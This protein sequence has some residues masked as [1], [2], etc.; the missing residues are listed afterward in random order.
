MMTDQEHVQIHQKSVIEL[1]LRNP[2]EVLST[3]YILKMEHN[4]SLVKLFQCYFSTNVLISNFFVLVT[5][6]FLI[7]WWCIYFPNAIKE[8]WYYIT[9]GVIYFLLLIDLGVQFFLLKLKL[10]VLLSGFTLT[11]GLI[12]VIISNF[13]PGIQGFLV[14]ALGIILSFILLAK[15]FINILNYRSIK[16]HEESDAQKMIEFYGVPEDS[17]IPPPNLKPTSERED[18]KLVD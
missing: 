3:D 1:G 10:K 9:I 13:L 8:L 4:R 14:G 16:K 17:N 2:T 18:K 7:F 5:C 6:S 15:N 12:L 11:I